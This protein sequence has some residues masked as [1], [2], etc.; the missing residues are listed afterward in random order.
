VAFF[1]GGEDD[2]IYPQKST[3]VY[4]FWYDGPGRLQTRL[5]HETRLRASRYNRHRTGL[6]L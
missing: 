1:G 2:P 6:F 4:W 5:Q 3:V